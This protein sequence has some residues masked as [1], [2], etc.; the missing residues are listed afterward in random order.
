MGPVKVYYHDSSRP[1]D[2]DSYHVPG[3]E[4]ETI[5]PPT[6]NLA[7]KGRPVGG[8][9]GGGGRAPA[10]AGAAAAGGRNAAGRGGP[11]VG[12]GGASV[13][14]FIESRGGPARPGI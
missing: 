6:N 10:A 3:M 12:A 14:V 8:R 1:E 7:D 13:K 9:G 4:S 5:L 2:P 11:L